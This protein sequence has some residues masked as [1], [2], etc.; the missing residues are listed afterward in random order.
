ME[1][2]RAILAEKTGVPIN[3]LKVIR[4]Y[5][6]EMVVKIVYTVLFGVVLFAVTFMDT[7]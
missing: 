1:T 3:F 4:I 5:K 7:L 6:G 2:A